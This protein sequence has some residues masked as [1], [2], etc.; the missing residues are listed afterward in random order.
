[1]RAAF[2]FFTRLPVGGFPYA[3]E[4][5]TWA[6]AHAPLV[7]LVVGAAVA[8]VDRAL[9]PAGELP[10]ALVA[11]GAS[12]LLTGAFHE[13]GLADTADAL[14]G[15]HDR[16][17][18]LAILKD[19]R[20]GS[21]GA[22]ALVVTLGARAALLAEL[23]S[24][25]PAALPLSFALARVVP[26]WL[27]TLLPYVT[28]EATAKSRDVARTTFAH[29]AVA[30]AWATVAL[31]AALAL[32]AC[33]PGRALSLVLVLCVTG[34]V[35]GWRYAQRLGGVTG[36]LLGATEQLAEIATLLVLAYR[37]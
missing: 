21:F 2:V 14:G 4:D 7:G 5:W 20:I 17:R 23:G 37:V 36:D 22:A 18:V 19:S 34:V 6:A 24:R 1:M 31:G 35:T 3:A 28:D 25:A 27:M 13:D 10:A 16:A 12:L 9:S 15:G 32:G 30:T 8:A 26:V 29:A 11:V 33:T